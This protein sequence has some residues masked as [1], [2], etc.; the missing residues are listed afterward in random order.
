[1]KDTDGMSTTTMLAEARAL[2][3]AAKRAND[4]ESADLLSR[5]ALAL[6]IEALA[7]AIEAAGQNGQP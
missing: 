7:L 5:Q 1:M 2:F 4:R 6:A 3:E